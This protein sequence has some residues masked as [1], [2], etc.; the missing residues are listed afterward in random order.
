MEMDKN[1]LRIVIQQRKKELSKEEK[2]ASS[3]AV[4]E[5]L[6]NSRVF[7]EAKHVLCYWSLFDELDTHDFVNKHYV[8]KRIYLPRVVGKEVEIVPYYGEASMQKGAFGIM[9]PQGSAISNYKEIDL[10]IV[11][12]VAFTKEGNRMGRG[13]GY[14]D[15]LLPLLTNAT[16]VGVCYQCQIL[17]HVPIEVHDIK[18]DLVIFS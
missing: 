4:F 17:D 16:K 8:S 1:D 7:Q 5:V 12:G 6:E 11:P 10:V 18:M 15:R 9:E 14:Y 3:K 13:G 2:K